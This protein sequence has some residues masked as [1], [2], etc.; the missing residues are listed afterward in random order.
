MISAAPALACATLAALAALACAGSTGP[1]AGQAVAVDEARGPR[2]LR[3]A[4]AAP[5]DLV[6][7]GGVVHTLVPDR[8]RP[9]DEA[10]RAFTSEPA[11]AAFAERH[12]A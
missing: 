7:T 4:G 2:D 6:L 11:Y 12:R 10:L 5:P 8:T 1:G 9:L 3:P